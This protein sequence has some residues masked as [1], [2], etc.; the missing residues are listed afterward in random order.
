MM[1]LARLRY[2]LQPRIGNAAAAYPFL[3]SGERRPTSHNALPPSQHTPSFPPLRTIPSRRLRNRPVQTVS[4]CMWPSIYRLAKTAAKR[5]KMGENGEGKTERLTAKTGRHPVRT[6]T[7]P[8]RLGPIIEKSELGDGIAACK[9]L[10]RRPQCVS[11]LCGGQLTAM[12]RQATRMGLGNRPP[13]RKPRIP[14]AVCTKSVEARSCW[15]RAS[16]VSL[17]FRLP[18]HP[19]SDVGGARSSLRRCLRSWSFW[20]L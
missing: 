3:A 18:P 11:T 14:H 17:F 12:L 13:A 8:F 19:V 15:L 1:R 5:T 9:P 4:V 10:N 20:S 16:T 6:G 2:G 7:G